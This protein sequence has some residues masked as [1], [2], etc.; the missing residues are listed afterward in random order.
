MD[1]GSRMV[2]ADEHVPLTEVALL[3]GYS[4]QSSFSRA[5]RSWTGLTPRDFRSRALRDQG[6]QPPGLPH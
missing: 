4:E 3:L 5:F 1:L 6:G 2:L